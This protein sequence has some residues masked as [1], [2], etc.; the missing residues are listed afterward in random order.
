MVY[1]LAFLG[2]VFLGAILPLQTVWTFGDV[3][4]GM[5]TI[6]NL[7]A[8]VFLSRQV[9]QMQDEYFAQ[10]HTPFNKKK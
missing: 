1:K 7:I 9:R 10:E 5:M 6:P 2:F 3:A 4:L 8:V